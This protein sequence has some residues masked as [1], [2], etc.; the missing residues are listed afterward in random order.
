[1]RDYGLNFLWSDLYS[2]NLFARGFEYSNQKIEA[3]TCFEV[4][5]HF[6]CPVEELEKILKISRNIFF[7]TLLL[8]S[9]ISKAELWAYYHFKLGQHMS[10]YSDKTLKYLAKKYKLNYY[11]NKNN[12]HLFT[13]KKF[14]RDFLDSPYL[15]LVYHLNP[16]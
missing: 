6:S 13:D 8:P 10:F 4:F 15:C 1:M 16:F 12:F 3:I 11:S 14:P 5:E 2:K 7:S 9:T